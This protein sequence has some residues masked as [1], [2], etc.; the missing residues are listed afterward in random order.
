MKELVF[1]ARMRG[2]GY[3]NVIDFGFFAMPTELA[4][5]GAKIWVLLRI[6]GS[7]TT[8]VFSLTWLYG[9]VS[10][11]A[12]LFLRSLVEKMRDAQMEERWHGASNRLEELLREEH[13]EFIVYGCRDWV[14]EKCREEERKRLSRLSKGRGM[15]I[16][17]RLGVQI[18]TRASDKL[19]EVSP[20]HPRHLLF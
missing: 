5:V 12:P 10:L 4:A 3:F 16:A 7:A 9:A 17:L 14:M 11:F 2:Q 13:E 1:A 19:F 6:M 15:Y 8:S 20:E 18:T